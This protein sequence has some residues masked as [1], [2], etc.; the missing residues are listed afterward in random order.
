MRISVSKASEFLHKIGSGHDVRITS[1]SWQPD[2]RVLTV[3]C[4][5]IFSAFQ[6][7]PESPGPLA[8]NLVFSNIT[9]FDVS[10]DSIDDY[11]SISRITCT[12]VGDGLDT[13]FELWLQGTLHA[14]A[15]E[16]LIEYDAEDA[17]RPAI[18][19]LLDI[20]GRPEVSR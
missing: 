7:M 17:H 6:E 4:D 1:L 14:V 11:L 8:V 16:M 5:D 9:H 18:N 10:I 3:S 15:K 20:L 2:T 19:K 12:E 13:V